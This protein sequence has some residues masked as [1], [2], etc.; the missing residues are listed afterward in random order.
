MCQKIL[1]LKKITKKFR[2]FKH[3]LGFYDLGVFEFRV[4]RIQGLLDLG[5][6]PDQ[7]TFGDIQL[8][9]SPR[10]L[11]GTKFDAE[12]AK[13]FPIG[14]ECPYREQGFSKIHKIC[15]FYIKHLKTPIC[16]IV[17]VFSGLFV[18][19]NQFKFQ[20]LQIP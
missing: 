1:E 3:V 4:F 19:S 13:M 11:Q 9:Y 12:N 7:I 6:P 2:G 5:L 8:L 16:T 20:K 17:I 10:S 15:Y 14:A 18:V